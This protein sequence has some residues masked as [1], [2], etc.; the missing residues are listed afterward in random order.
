MI[1]SWH[2]KWSYR[3]W[4]FHRLYQLSFVLFAV[5]GFGAAVCNLLLFIGP[6]KYNDP[7]SKFIMHLMP[8]LIWAQ[9][10]TQLL[11]AQVIFRRCP[12]TLLEW[13]LRSEEGLKRYWVGRLAPRRVVPVL[14]GVTGG[15]YLLFFW[16]FVLSGRTF[17][18]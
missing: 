11:T 16:L 6:D 1:P 13:H 18:S 3:V 9:L 15:L 14:V 7:V 10:L 12:L 8:Q 17:L 5:I 4:R 2:T